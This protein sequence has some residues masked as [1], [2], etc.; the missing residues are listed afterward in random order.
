[1]G[2]VQHRLLSAPT[3]LLGDQL[4]QSDGT[5]V[6]MGCLLHCSQ[7]IPTPKSALKQGLFAALLLCRVAPSLD[8]IGSNGR[9]WVSK[10]TGEETSVPGVSPSER[11]Q[12]YM[13]RGQLHRTA[14]ASARRQKRPAPSRRAPVRS[15]RNSGLVRLSGG[16][17]VLK[18]PLDGARQQWKTNMQS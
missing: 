1:M 16:A 14:H 17:V 2:R 15:G 9:Q 13:L 7:Q 6:S 12:G 11:L 18:R 8:P 3:L 5:H 4:R 10:E